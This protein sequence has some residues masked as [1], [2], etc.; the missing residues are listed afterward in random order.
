MT[1]VL[2]LLYNFP[3]FLSIAVFRNVNILCLWQT[4]AQVK[5]KHALVFP[6]IIFYINNIY[7]NNYIL[8]VSTVTSC[9]YFIYFKMAT[10]RT[11][12]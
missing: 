6:Q 4:V 12:V 10:D 9:T 8:F 2:E 1:F 11:S 5:C 3:A 7:I